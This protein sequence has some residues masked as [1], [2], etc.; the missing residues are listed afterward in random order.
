MSRK[1][2]KQLDKSANGWAAAMIEAERQIVQYKR[3]IYEL[4]ESLKIMRTKIA[5][6]EP[7]PG[8]QSDAQTSTEQHSV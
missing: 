2:D 7:W 1:K 8:T 6:G 4:G 3:K 5:D